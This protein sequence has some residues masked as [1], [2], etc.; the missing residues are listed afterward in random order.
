[1]RRKVRS[2]NPI[3]CPLYVRIEATAP[4]GVERSDRAQMV[5]RIVQ[6]TALRVVSGDLALHMNFPHNHPEIDTPSHTREQERFRQD[7]PKVE[8]KLIKKLGFS[9]GNPL[10]GFLVTF[11]PHKKLPGVWGRAAPTTFPGP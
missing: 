9:G 1:M 8:R 4:R 7:G 10:N 11:C 2:A 3:C 5:L 6:R